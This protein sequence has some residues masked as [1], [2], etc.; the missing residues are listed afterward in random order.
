MG[1]VRE[2]P[3]QCLTFSKRSE[4]YSLR[5]AATADRPTFCGGV[6]ERPSSVGS[7]GCSKSGWAGCRFRLHFHMTKSFCLSFFSELLLLLCLCALRDLSL[8]SGPP[9]EFLIAGKDFFLLNGAQPELRR[10]VQYP[11]FG[12]AQQSQV[13]VAGTIN[14]PPWEGRSWEKPLSDVPRHMLTSFKSP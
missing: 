4:V 7:A 5:G 13:S 1:W 10:P 8:R 2:F 14:R 6:S 9:D 3:N 11:V 12:L